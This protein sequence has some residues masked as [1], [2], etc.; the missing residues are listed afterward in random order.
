MGAEAAGVSA[1]LYIRDFILDSIDLTGDTESA[2]PNQ[3]YPE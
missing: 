1:R 3:Q 2:K